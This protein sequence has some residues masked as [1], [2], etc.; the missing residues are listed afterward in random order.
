MTPSQYIS[1]E[2]DKIDKKRTFSLLGFLFI[3]AF[4]PVMFSGS[5]EKEGNQAQTAVLAEQDT[6]IIRANQA[7]S[8]PP[9]QQLLPASQSGTTSVVPTQNTQTNTMPMQEEAYSPQPSIWL[10]IIPIIITFFTILF[11]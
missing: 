3:L 5:N 6:N 1:Q 8:S 9:Q 4:F 10:F 11:Y 7:V 2:F